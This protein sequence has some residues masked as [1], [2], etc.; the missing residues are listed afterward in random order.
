MDVSTLTSLLR[1]AEEHHGKYEENSAPHHWSGWYAAFV[2]SR[3]QGRTPEESYDDATRH[4]EGE[5]Q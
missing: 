4:L 1:E 5:A 3:E 2:L